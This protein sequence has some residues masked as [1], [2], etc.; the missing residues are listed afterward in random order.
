M[1]RYSTRRVIAAR[2]STTSSRAQSRHVAYIA[3][4]GNLEY[5]LGMYVE[6]YSMR[7]L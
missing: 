2:L 3:R 1:P 7:E 6:D 4:T 5:Q